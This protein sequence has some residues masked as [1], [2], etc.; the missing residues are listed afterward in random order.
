MIRGPLDVGLPAQGVDAAACHADISQ[1]Q[2]DDGRKA[3]VLDAHG[4]LRPAQG[5]HDGARLVRMRPWR[6]RSHRP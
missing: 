5:V 1:Q 2:L 6:H 3:D 4:V